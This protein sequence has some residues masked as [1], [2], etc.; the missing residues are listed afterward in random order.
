MALSANEVR[1]RRNTGGLKKGSAAVATSAVVYQG[2]HLAFVEATGRVKAGDNAAG[3]TYVGV[4]ASAGT[5]T[6]DAA[7]TVVVEYEFGFEQ[8]EALATAVTKAYTGCNLSL[9]DDDTLSTLSGA[10]TAGVRCIVGEL[11]E[12]VAANSGWVAIREFGYKDA[13]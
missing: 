9:T 4:C 1:K 10:G 13:P 8:L 7:G 12:F 3:L 11:R 6:G 2:S 5:K